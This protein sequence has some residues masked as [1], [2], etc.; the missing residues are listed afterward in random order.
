M[1]TAVGFPLKAV[2]GFDGYGFVN[3]IVVPARAAAVRSPAFAN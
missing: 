3:V 2:T 1:A